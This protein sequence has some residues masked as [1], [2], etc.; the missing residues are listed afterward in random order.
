MPTCGAPTKKNGTPCKRKVATAGQRCSLHQ[1]ATSVK[2]ET[3]A[4]KQAPAHTTAR[5][6]ARTNTR[7]TAADT[8]RH[9]LAHPPKK[10]QSSTMQAYKKECMD[11]LDRM[12]IDAAAKDG[13]LDYDARCAQ[14]HG[15]KFKVVDVHAGKVCCGEVSKETMKQKSERI[16]RIAV[17]IA[18]V[19]TTKKDVQKVVELTESIDPSKTTWR[20]VLRKLFGYVYSL[21]S[22]G[23]RRPVT[24][25][26][27]TSAIVLVGYGIT[28]T[29]V[30]DLT[31]SVGAW[32]VGKSMSGLTGRAAAHAA[33][34]EL[35]NAQ[36]RQY[37]MLIKAAVPVF[38]GALG[39]AI[40]G[41]AVGTFPVSVGVMAGG[42]AVGAMMDAQTFEKAA[43]ATAS[44]ASATIPAMQTTGQAS[45]TVLRVVGEQFINFLIYSASLE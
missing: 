9:L 1:A 26:L 18:E 20:G 5:T 45:K 33:S 32:E 6:T 42:T 40:S 4:S 29:M 24:L 38:Q 2:K 25:M 31:N 34:T 11:L 44:V 19:T 22:F 39:V 13:V 14:R 41:A 3:G 28:S 7:I 10:G 23:I 27:M 17:K 15:S 8:H 43:N 12:C 35:T 16:L 36:T 30:A 21:L 37:G